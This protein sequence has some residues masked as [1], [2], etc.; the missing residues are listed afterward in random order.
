MFMWNQMEHINNGRAPKVLSPKVNYVCPKPSLI[1][2]LARRA[3]GAS[4]A[5]LHQAHQGAR[6]GGVAHVGVD[7]HLNMSGDLSHMS[8][9]DIT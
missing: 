5:S 9:C 8:I 7:A 1:L 3:Q 4:G 6:A 2:T